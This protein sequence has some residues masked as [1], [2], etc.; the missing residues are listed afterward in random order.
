MAIIFRGNRVYCYTSGRGADGRVRGVY[1]GSGSAGLLAQAALDGL[2]AEW[3]AEREALAAAWAEET[4]H[5]AKVENIII[6]SLNKST[7]AF[8]LAMAAGGYYLHKRQ[9]RPMGKTRKAQQNA[10]PAGDARRMFEGDDS[11]ALAYGGDTARVAAEALI[12]AYTDDPD[13]REA[14]RR[15]Y[16]QRVRELAGESPTAVEVVLAEAVALARLDAHYAAAAYYR[17]MDGGGL[18]LE[19]GDYYQRRHS[20]AQRRLLAAC[21][22]LEA[23]RRLALPSKRREADATAPTPPACP[24]AVKPTRPTRYGGR[25]AGVVG[26]RRN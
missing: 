1:L 12:D 14:L 25:L 7:T 6:D 19:H 22:E 16:H 11:P 17:V 5:E 20:R 21:R 9:W 15:E 26:A 18:S 13:C 23:C 2:R 8:R 4:A 3:R 10:T 24:L